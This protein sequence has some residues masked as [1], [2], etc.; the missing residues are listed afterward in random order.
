MGLLAQSAPLGVTR[1]LRV[2]LVAVFLA[3]C[4][5]PASGPSSPE[6][7]TA[8][9]T[10]HPVDIRQDEPIPLDTP[11]PKYQDYFNEIRQ[12]IRKTWIYPYTASS[13][14]IEGDVE[15]DFRI[16]KT[17]D[18]KS[19]EQRRSSGVEILD[20][21]AMHAVQQASPFPPVP[22]RISKGSLP[23][24]GIFRY[25]ITPSL[26]GGTND[27]CSGRGGSWPACERR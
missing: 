18:L 10:P 21:Y 17:G 2:V 5:S 23:I 8:V 16:A 25:R 19:I 20:E 27:L 9:S 3:A 22:D 13:R 4:A 11:D 1:L 6:R 12:R 26:Q 7:P 15:I 24:H 14:G